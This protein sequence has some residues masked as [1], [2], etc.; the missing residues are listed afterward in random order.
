MKASAPIRS[1]TIGEGGG[2]DRMRVG[3]KRG[4]PVAGEIVGPMVTGMRVIM[5]RVEVGDNSISSSIVEGSCSSR[6]NSEVTI[7]QARLAVTNTAKIILMLNA[8][9]SSPRYR[10]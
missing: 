1:D 3:V 8:N 9:S 4:I 10:N 7:L 6:S 5:N 2:I